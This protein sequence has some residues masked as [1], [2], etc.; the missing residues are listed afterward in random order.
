MRKSSEDPCSLMV[1]VAGHGFRKLL[2]HY[3]RVRCG[4]IEDGIS[5]AHIDSRTGERDEAGWVI[6]LEDLRR[7][8]D[9]AMS[10]PRDGCDVYEA[11][12]SDPRDG[13]DS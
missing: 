13:D 12:M 10:E 5:F 11:E 7:I 1:D 8:Y 9:A 2:V 4:G 6:S 3:S